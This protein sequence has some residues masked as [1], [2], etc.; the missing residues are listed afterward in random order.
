MSAEIRAKRPSSANSRRRIA[1]AITIGGVVVLLAGAGALYS[2]MRRP[3]EVAAIN[4]PTHLAE[5]VGTPQ[6]EKPA[7]KPADKPPEP[8][9]EF[10]LAV[11]RQGVVYIRSLFL[12]RPGSVTGTGFLVSKDG[13]IYTN[14]HVIHP[15]KKAINTRKVLVGVPSAKDVEI[16]EYFLAEVVYEP[17]LNEGLDFA[18]LKI[19]AKPGYGEFRSLPL[20][21]DK[22]ELGQNVAALGFPFIQA[23]A[24]TFS[25]NRGGIS[26][27]KVEFNRKLFLQTDAAVNPGNSGGPLVNQRGEVLAIVTLKMSNANNMG[28]ALYLSETQEARKLADPMIAAARPEPGPGDYSDTRLLLE[29]PPL[30]VKPT[31]NVPNLSNPDSNPAPEKPPPAG[32]LKLGETQTVGDIQMTTLLLDRMGMAQSALWAL[33]G[34]SFYLLDYRW[35][36]RRM[37]A[38]SLKEEARAEIGTHADHLALSAEGIVVTATNEKQ[39]LVLDPISLQTL[40]KIDAG[41]AKTVISAPSLSVAF[42]VG[43][44]TAL[45]VY[46]LKAGKVLRQIVGTDFDKPY[47]RDFNM[48][49]ITPDAKYLFASNGP[50]LLRFAIKPDGVLEF[51]EASYD[52]RITNSPMY[53][54]VCDNAYVALPG[55]YGNQSKA[56]DH[57]VVKPYHTYVYPVDN[58]RQPIFAFV[59]HGLVFDTKNNALY[60]TSNMG[61][62]SLIR[63][64]LNGLSLKEYQLGTG[65]VRHILP[66]PQGERLLLLA[67]RATALVT[68]PKR[69]TTP[70]NPA[71]TMTTRKVADLKLADVPLAT[72]A[73]PTSA[74]WSA[75]GKTLFTVD[76]RGTVCRLSA[77]PLKEEARADLG[78]LASGLSLSTEG[79][80]V[81]V[82][83]RSQILVLDPVTLKTSSKIETPRLNRLA[84]APGLSLAV[85]VGDRTPIYLIDLK[86]GKVV[87]EMVG[88]DFG[89]E[90]AVV[91]DGV[92]FTPNGK[93]L[94]VSDTSAILRFR[95]D[96][97]KVEFEESGYPIRSEG[98]SFVN[99]FCDDEQVCMPDGR[100]NNQGLQDHPSRGGYECFV[101][102]VKNLR[103]PILTTNGAAHWS[104]IPIASRGIVYSTSGKP[105]VSLRQYD[106]AGKLFKEYS[107]QVGN[108]KSI[109]ADL[110]GD[111]LALL[112]EKGLSVVTLPAR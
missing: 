10:N 57:W 110:A 12:P 1:L 31:P 32:P 86:A 7:E 52:I 104:V 55:G 23:D 101:Y 88:K 93:Y 64:N 43:N 24:P 73:I 65:Q 54:I 90:A 26:A 78:V 74:A 14:R 76:G 72:E 95:V 63:Y 70:A 62:T 82:A 6:E 22:V 33:D 29:R 60:G 17:N 80:V 108:V 67:D 68:L 112:T 8:A 49:E 2:F 107:F 4:V 96:G 5:N 83:G 44:N 85:G 109:V 98:A 106:G 79:L 99:I 102:P 77:E 91:F 35:T 34:K 47:Y 92:A 21:V 56:K 58:I 105:D 41:L 27:T 20:T 89:V 15:E 111:R 100:G 18:I 28:Y 81:L 38:E 46:D 19:A 71:S 16:L 59:T 51:Q 13:L 94:F 53:P 36:V 69:G 40:R 75:D 50:A 97:M 25:F 66:Q 84:S 48:I 9:R 37:N 42:G 30:V 103:K 3:A 61:A 45:F 87:Q 11:A 39:V